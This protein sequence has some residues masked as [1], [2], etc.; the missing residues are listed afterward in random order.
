MTTYEIGT[1]ASRTKI[2]TEADVMTFADISGDDNPIHLDDE[3]ARKTRFG[4]RIAHGILTGSLIS[5]ILGRDF[6]G[7]GTIYLS[8]SFNFKAP[9]FIGDEITAQVELKAFRADKRIA[10]F[11]TTCTNQDGTLVL[12]GEAIVIAPKTTS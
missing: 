1:I 10:T 3:Y 7:E 6:P 4:K 9:V 12:D 2:M 11:Y 5:T 8:Q